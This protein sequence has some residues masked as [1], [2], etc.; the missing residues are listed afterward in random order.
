[1]AFDFARARAEAEDV[2]VLEPSLE[3]LA[4]LPIEQQMRQPASVRVRLSAL[5]QTRSDAAGQAAQATLQRL[6]SLR[7]VGQRSVRP[8]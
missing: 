8:V 5:H 3:E 1:M 6:L 4:A 7:P 2:V